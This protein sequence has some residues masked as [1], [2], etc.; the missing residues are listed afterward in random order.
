MDCEDEE[1]YVRACVLPVVGEDAV[2]RWMAC[3]EMEGYGI[4]IAR[5]VVVS[6][7]VVLMSR[8]RR[9]ESLVI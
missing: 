9:T 5:A 3:R 4:D 1:E 6:M 7:V 2:T 8:K